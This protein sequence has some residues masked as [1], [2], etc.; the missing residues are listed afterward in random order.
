MSKDTIAD[1]Q[2][3]TKLYSEMGDGELLALDAEIADLTELARQV[4]RDE[5]SKRRLERPSAAK[6]AKGP[7]E[8]VAASWPDR[9]ADAPAGEDES[10]QSDQPREYSWKTPLCECE[11]GEIA[12]QL[13]QA[14]REA[15]IENWIDGPRHANV[16]EMSHAQILVAADQLEEAQE[17]AARPIPQAIVEQSR[18]EVPDYEP[19]LCPACGAEDPVLESADPANAWLCEACGK[20]WT[21]SGKEPSENATR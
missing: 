17:I 9:S 6:A 5:M 7:S 16:L 10:W 12:W 3:L 2:S 1:W 19:P 4:L 11:S 18:M 14:L 15:G 21:E 20:Q 8:R 13:Q